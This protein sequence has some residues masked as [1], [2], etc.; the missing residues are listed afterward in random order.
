[1]SNLR[2]ASLNVASFAMKC[3]EEGKDDKY[4]DNKKYKTLVK[5]ISTLIQKNGFI[6]TL[7]FVLSKSNIENPKKEDIIKKQYNNKI[8][9]DII[10][11][12]YENDKINNLIDF[13]KYEIDIND[14]D[15]KYNTINIAKYIQAVT[16]LN[17]SQ[18]KLITKEMMS[19]FGWIKR[20]ADGMIEGE[21]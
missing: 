15:D 2:N 1:M 14:N 16:E 9:N 5:K 20:F 12:N 17:Q 11:W 10:K 19:L 13:E 18:Y 3:V 6:N 8:L 21:G 7:V 4:I